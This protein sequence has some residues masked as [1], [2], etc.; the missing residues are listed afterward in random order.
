MQHATACDPGTALGQQAACSWLRQPSTRFPTQ[1]NPN[2][3]CRREDEQRNGPNYVSQEQP[4]PGCDQGESTRV[5][6]RRR[7]AGCLS[8]SRE[9]VCETCRASRLPLLNPLTF[10]PLLRTMSSWADVLKLFVANIPLAATVDDIRAAFKGCGRV[11]SAWLP[12]L[13]LRALAAEP[14]R[15]PTRPVRRLTRAHASPAPCPRASCPS[16]LCPLA[17]R[18]CRSWWRETRPP[19][20]PRA[21]LTCGTRAAATATWP[22]S[23][24]AC[25]WRLRAAGPSCCGLRWPDSAG[26]CS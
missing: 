20:S 15:L 22:V 18:L 24:R 1:L 11:R 10:P 19:G 12:V 7:P 21:A 26:C 14:A 4:P 13:L 9:A 2:P 5:P 16:P 17:S 8:A 25:R 23:L 3:P 6:P